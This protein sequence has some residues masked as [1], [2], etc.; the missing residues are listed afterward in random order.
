MKKNTSIVLTII[1]LSG[2]YPPPTFVHPC[3]C[4]YPYYVACPNYDVLGFQ[5][6]AE[7]TPVLV[8]GWTK[9][10]GGGKIQIRW[11][12]WALYWYSSSFYHSFFSAV[13]LFTNRYFVHPST[14]DYILQFWQY[15]WWV[16]TDIIFRN[17][18]VFFDI[19][20]LD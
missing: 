12:L 1:I 5:P 4:R 11:L 2:F 10:G 14:K 8:S 16:D 17:P 18:K 20:K 3:V 13:S 6:Q 15:H 19:P 9:V 7:V